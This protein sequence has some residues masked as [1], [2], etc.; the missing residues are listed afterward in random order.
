MS[1]PGASECDVLSSEL[2][3]LDVTP[4]PPTACIQSA[5]TTEELTSDTVHE[6][7]DMVLVLATV[8]GLV[9]ID[10]ILNKT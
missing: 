7:A 10:R 4:D 8:E 6:R 9:R 1:R 2:T 5:L 3:T